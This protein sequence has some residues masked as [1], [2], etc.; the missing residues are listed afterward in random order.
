MVK[1]LRLIQNENMK[2][3]NRIGTYIMIALLLLASLGYTIANKQLHADSAFGEIPQNPQWKEELQSQNNEYAKVIADPNQNYRYKQ[4]LEN[5]IATNEYRLAHNL[6]ISVD[7]WSY[8]DESRNI[9]VLVTLFAIFAVSTS[10]AGEFSWGTIKLLL[11][12]PIKRRKI[13]LAKYLSSLYYA[14]T[15]LTLLFVSS[16]I[17]GG[18][19]FGWS[20][21]SIALT[22]VE[23]EVIEKSMFLKALTNYGYSIVEMVMMVSFAFM[24]STLFRSSSMATGVS[25]ALYLSSS[26]ITGILLGMNIEWVKYSFLTNLRLDMYATHSPFFED[27]TLPF[28]VT[29]LSIHL[30]LFLLVSWTVFQR[31][32]VTN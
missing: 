6:P 27:M 11:L 14:L 9:I 19:F 23:G 15:L 7:M 8:L 18:I 24:I 32:D 2:T 25:I 1:L 28:S 22:I 4:N 26:T 3:F 31:R 29:I 5:R 13:L 30:L 21:P 16:L 10:V 20:S 17:F 12:R